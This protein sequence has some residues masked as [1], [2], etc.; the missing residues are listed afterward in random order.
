LVAGL[1]GIADLAVL[2]GSH[3]GGNVLEGSLVQVE[4]T[5]LVERHKACPGTQG[6]EDHLDPN[7]LA[8]ED[9]IVDTQD[10]DRKEGREE[11]GHFAAVV[12][13]V[14]LGEQMEE[15]GFDVEGSQ[16]VVLGEDEIRSAW[17]IDQ[18]AV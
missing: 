12:D 18:Q 4:D 11:E 7:C 14:G 6:L 16:L 13:L 15:V 2:E 9:R 10:V 5:I 8:E 17:K 3:M 1:A